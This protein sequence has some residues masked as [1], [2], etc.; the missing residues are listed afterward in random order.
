MDL[1]FVV[2]NLKEKKIKEKVDYLPKKIVGRTLPKS[3]LWYWKYYLPVLNQFRT[4]FRWPLPRPASAPTHG[5]GHWSL[6]RAGSTLSKRV[7]VCPRS[8]PSDPKL[9]AC[10]H[11]RF[12]KWENWGSERGRRAA[13]SRAEPGAGCSVSLTAEPTWSEKSTAL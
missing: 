4:P 7:A 3:C 8:H 6:W 1:F 12:Y 5:S 10:H 11:C 13:K 2:K 9:S